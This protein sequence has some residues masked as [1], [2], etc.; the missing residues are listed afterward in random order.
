[1][2]VSLIVLSIWYTAMV[3]RYCCMLSNRRRQYVLLQDQ[4]NQIDM[5]TAV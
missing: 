1:M 5:P 2:T 3:I 4:A